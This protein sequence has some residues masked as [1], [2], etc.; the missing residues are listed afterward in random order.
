MST[1]EIQLRS[2]L[3]WAEATENYL[4]NHLTDLDAQI[5]A[6]ESEVKAVSRRLRNVGEIRARIMDCISKLEDGVPC[7][8]F[9]EVLEIADR[10]K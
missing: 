6:L 9:D 8:E 2:D 4:H 5:R 3:G 1:I 7:G 10:L